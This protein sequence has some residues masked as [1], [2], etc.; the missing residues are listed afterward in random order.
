MAFTPDNNNMERKTEVQR[1]TVLQKRKKVMGMAGKRKRRRNGRV[2]IFLL[3]MLITIA[4]GSVVLLVSWAFLGNRGMV[5]AAVTVEGEVFSLFGGNDAET[6]AA[7]ETE[8]G[9]YADI[10]NNPELMAQQN[11]YTITPAAE[12]EVSLVFAGDILFDDG[13]SIMA[14]MKSRGQ[15]IEGSIDSGLLGVMR[16]AD[17]FMVNNE[18]TYTKRGAPTPGKAFTFRAD[19]AHASLLH[20]MG[21]DLVSLAN[22]HAYDYGEV[23]LTDTL[24]TLQSIG[25]P[26]AGAGRNLAEAVRPVYYIAGD[27]KIAFLS[28][29]Q[30]ERVDNPDTK[31]AT[32][33]SPG[34]FRCRDVDMLLQAV[35][36]AKANSDFVVVY[37]HWGTE[38]TTELDWAQKEQAPRIAAAGADLIIGDHPHV[39]QGIDYIGN[40]PVIYSLGNFLFNSKTQDT[41]LVRAILDEESGS[42]KSFQFIPALQKDCRTTIHEGTEKA[43]VIG[44]MRSLSPK[45]QIDEE[46]YVAVPEN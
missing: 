10:L 25:M 30:I 33:T 37:I 38:S 6:E 1:G 39:L 20:D 26:Y 35:S 34:V 29:T 22:N 9:K 42:L 13:Y 31:G 21:A 32:E 18:F 23:S 3:T 36:E 24:D 44:H 5:L 4:V 45:V 28:A 11:I 7:A 27:L 8:Q 16:D 43:R 15:G 19:P 2:S 41:C 46:G 12:G 17:I 14:K 40:T